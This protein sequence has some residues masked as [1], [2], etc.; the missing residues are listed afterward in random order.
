MLINTLLNH[1]CYEIK[2]VLRHIQTKF[3]AQRRFICPKGQKT[4]N[5]RQR[6]RMRQR[7]K[8]RRG[9]GWGW[10]GVLK[11]QRAVHRE[12]TGMAHR[13]MEVYK[14]IPGNLC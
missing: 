12:K 13:Q 5:R 3:S 14:G 8:G 6:Y 2:D 11:G 4:S 10:R 9:L 1:V 7:G